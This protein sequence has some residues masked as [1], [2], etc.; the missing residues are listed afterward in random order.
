MTCTRIE[1]RERERERRRERRAESGTQTVTYD[2]NNNMLCIDCY[3]TLSQVYFGMH[4]KLAA[5][6]KAVR[7]QEPRNQAGLPHA[8]RSLVSALSLIIETRL[9]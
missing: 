8:I 4:V 6:I 7:V 9:F 5:S 1:Y 3:L 2:S